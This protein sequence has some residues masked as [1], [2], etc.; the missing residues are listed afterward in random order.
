MVVADT[1]DELKLTQVTIQCNLCYGAY[2]HSHTY[3]T[4]EEL[5]REPHAIGDHILAGL[6]YVSPTLHERT[7]ESSREWQASRR[8][9][10][11]SVI[12]LKHVPTVLHYDSI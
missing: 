1:L 11:P 2:L 6:A 12:I 4:V 3:K 9:L 5:A 8:I 7:L 10:I